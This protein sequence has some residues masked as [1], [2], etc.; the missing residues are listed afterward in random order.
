MNNAFMEFFNDEFI[1]GSQKSGQDDDP[2]IKSAYKTLFKKILNCLPEGIWIYNAEGKVVMIN[3]AAEW[4][5]GIEAKEMLGKT[6]HEIYKKG[7]FDCMVAPE[8]FKSKKEV[9]LLSYTRRTKKRLLITGNPIL[10]NNGDVYLVVNTLRDVTKLSRIQEK[11]KETQEVTRKIKDELTELNLLELKGKEII[12]ESDS[13][14]QVLNVAIKFASIEVRTILITGETGVGKGILSK[15]IHINS[16]RKGET[17]VQINCAALPENL[18]EAELFGYEPGAFTGASKDGKIGLLELADKGT[19]FLDEI[20]ELPFSIQAKLLKF[21]EDHEIMRLGGVRR[22]KV[23]CIIIAATNRELKEMIKR[24][25]FR[26]DLYYRLEAF[27]I[28]I[29]PLRKR[30]EDIFELAKYYLEKYNKR[31]NKKAKISSKTMLKLTANDLPGNSRQ[32][33]NIFNMAVA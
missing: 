16:N 23:D 20:G 8:V 2:S 25:K 12:A 5:E 11:L 14:K 18:L 21:L 10:D 26:R 27:T 19:L 31:Y 15:F 3:H 6:H 1:C 24:K 22:K 32:L 30:P 17:F 7:I 9:S 13:M 29:P 4:L 33:K 28:H